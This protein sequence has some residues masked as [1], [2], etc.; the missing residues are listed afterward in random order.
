MICYFFPPCAIVGAMRSSKFVKYLGEFG[1]HSTVLTSYEGGKREYDGNSRVDVHST[2]MVELNALWPV[3]APM[4]YLVAGI[5][6]KLKGWFKGRS[7][8]REPRVD[9]GPVAATAE[10]RLGDRIKRWLLV[11]D[12]QVLWIPLALPKA[13]R[14]ARQCDVIYTSLSPFSAHVL[15]LIVKKMTRRPWVADY[16]DEWSLNRGWLPPTRFHRWLGEKLDGACVRSAD[17]VINTTETRTTMFVEHFGGPNEKAVTIHNGYDGEDIAKYRDVPA[18]TDG[19]VMTSIGSLYGGRD[20]RPFLQAVDQLVEAGLI[21]RQG[22][23]IRLIGDQ[24]Q[25]LV[26]GIDALGISDCVECWP[27]IPQEQAFMQLAKS[28]VALLVGSDMERVAMT[29]KVYEYVGMGKPILALVPEGPVH[30][31]VKRSGGWCAA[32]DNVADIKNVLMQ[33]IGLRRQGRSWP[34]APSDFAMKYERRE[35]TRQLSRCFNSCIAPRPG[36]V[37]SPPSPGD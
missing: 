9:S 26:V 16:R 29:T 14:L 3:V 13:L 28:H 2:L 8:K 21:D 33:M 4:V 23:K 34:Q 25:H 1:W 20:P 27:R 36:L 35:L 24:D 11:P 6:G 12:V 32:P 30:D 19:F 17:I 31:F 37:S 10:D 18:P 22:L 15:G 7:R 5:V